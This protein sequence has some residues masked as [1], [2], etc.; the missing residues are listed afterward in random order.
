MVPKGQQSAGGRAARVACPYQEFGRWT[1]VLLGTRIAGRHHSSSPRPSPTLG[2]GTPHPHTGKR[3][4]GTT[5]ALGR[6]VSPHLRCGAAWLDA[7]STASWE[8]PRAAFDHRTRERYS[9]LPVVRA[10]KSVRWSPSCATPA[11]ITPLRAL[12]I[13]SIRCRPAP[14]RPRVPWG[15]GVVKVAA[16]PPRLWH[17]GRGTGGVPFFPNPCLP[18]SPG[19]FRAPGCSMGLRGAVDAWRRRAC[20]C[21]REGLAHTGPLWA[22][23]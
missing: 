2:R 9:D 4:G 1:S 18:L 5:R 3:S 14:L 22:V 13:G 16:G 21:A 20:M 17:F 12:L 10:F 7:L 8:R 6:R 19:F 23:S 11:W 15:R